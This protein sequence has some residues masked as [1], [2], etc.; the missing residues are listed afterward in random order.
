LSS[1]RCY[2]ADIAGRILKQ[3]ALEILA[4]SPEPGSRR[5][6]EF[7]ELIHNFSDSNAVAL[8]RPEMT[9]AMQIQI[10]DRKTAE[11][12]VEAQ[13]ALALWQSGCP[14]LGSFPLN[15]DGQLFVKD[16]LIAFRK[17]DTLTF[18]PDMVACSRFEAPLLFKPKAASGARSLA[19]I[20]QLSDLHR[21]AAGTSLE[22]EL[23]NTRLESL[24]SCH[25]AI[26]PAFRTIEESGP[27]I[28]NWVGNGVRTIYARGTKDKELHS[29][30]AGNFAGVVSFALPI[31]QPIVSE[32]LVHEASHQH[33]FVVGFSAP[34]VKPDAP[35][36]YSPLKET[37]RPLKKLLLGYHAVQ[38]ILCFY[39][40]HVWTGEVAIRRIRHN[41]SCAAAFER[42]IES[43][44]T[45]L[46]EWGM[47][48]YRGIED[49]MERTRADLSS[50]VKRL[51]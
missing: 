5:I 43:V 18:G 26:G 7:A 1:P 38:A 40:R 27:D 32:L 36:A 49:E 48:L 12:F 33:F 2:R 22:Y 28:T 4:L 30:S 29:G 20:I 51:H 25:A 45:H 13:L 47:E 50:Y 23:A 9:Q 21:S 31:P 41:L 34:L 19:Q 35:E 3:I 10:E 24:A 17:G 37:N 8:W 44:S 46:T 14:V 6:A 16:S 39:G 42:S 15:A 11:E